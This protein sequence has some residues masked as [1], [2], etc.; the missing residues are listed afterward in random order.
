MLKGSDL[1]ASDASSCNFSGAD[2]SMA[3]MRGARI[4]K[5]NFTKANLTMAD[6]S[7]C[8]LAGSDFSGAILTGVNIANS[9]ISGT[10][11]DALEEPEDNKEKNMGCGRET[12]GAY[13]E[14]ALREYLS[15]HP[16]HSSEKRHKKKMLHA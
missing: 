12:L 9:I 16:E 14:K 11:L 10:V 1:S 7:D 5:G 6:L 13:M 3:N 2:L 15:Q 4:I 8:N